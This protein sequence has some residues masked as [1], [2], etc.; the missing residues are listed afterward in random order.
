MDRQKEAETN[1]LNG[2]NCSQAVA[3]AFHDKVADKMDKDALLMLASP[4][5]GGMGRLREACGGFTGALMILGLLEGNPDPEDQ[6]AKAAHY[7]RVQKLGFLFREAMGSL[8]CREIIGRPAES[9]PVPEP[10]TAQYYAKRPECLKA[11]RA[12]AAALEKLL[13]EV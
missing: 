3:L 13:S 11:V 1:F 2:Y 6:Q 4:F 5:G 12:G 7:A 9:S 8:V 10:R